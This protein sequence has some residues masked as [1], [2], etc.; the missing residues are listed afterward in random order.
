MGN[1]E[2]LRRTFGNLYGA[3]DCPNRGL[4]R[5]QIFQNDDVPTENHTSN[6]I[7]CPVGNMFVVAMTRERDGF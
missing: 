6:I 5:P 3:L 4:M 7:L 1:G 2:P